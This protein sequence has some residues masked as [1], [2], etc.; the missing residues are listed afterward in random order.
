MVFVFDAITAL[1]FYRSIYPTERSPVRFENIPAWEECAVTEEDVWSMAPAFVT[2]SF[3]ECVGG[4]I[5]VTSFDPTRRLK[6]KTHQ[7]HAWAGRIPKDSFCQFDVGVFLPSPQFIFLQA[8]S[9]LN[10]AQL[11]ALG[12]ELCGTY[13]FDKSKARGLRQR[14]VPLTSVHVLDAYLSYAKGCR[15]Y[16]RAKRALGHI[17]DGSAS[18]A[19]T[20]DEMELCLPHKLGG[21]ALEKPKMNEQIILSR[22]ASVVAKKTFCRADLLWKR[23]SPNDS[24]IIEHQGEFDHMESNRFNDDRARVNALRLMGY[25]VIELTRSQVWDLRVFEEIALEI[26][27]RTGKRIRTE[28]RGLTPQRKEL[29]SILADWNASYGRKM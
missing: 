8:A 6:S 28:N 9:R 25:E 5:H 22:Q 14:E 27:K 7:T 21:Y 26:A 17:V 12:D 13:S 3:L 24:T 10:L 19:E 20:R 18:P 16:N 11:I 1:E 23:D 4:V 29:R 2:P 15:G